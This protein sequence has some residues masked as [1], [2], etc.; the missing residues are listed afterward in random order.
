[1]AFVLK[2]GE[3]RKRKR[4]PVYACKTILIGVLDIHCTIVCNTLE[5]HEPASPY[6]LH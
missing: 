4:D 5:L 1:M 2:R 3:G 6:A